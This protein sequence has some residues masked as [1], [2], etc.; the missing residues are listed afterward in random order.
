MAD[1]GLAA[2]AIVL[3]VGAVLLFFGWLAWYGNRV[4]FHPASRRTRRRLALVQVVLGIFALGFFVGAA[5]TGGGF[6]WVYLLIASGQ[7]I[8][9]LA[10]FHDLRN[11][12]TD[13]R[14]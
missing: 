8:G 13:T 10:R 3:V 14:S 4:A 1:P 7:L 2:L 12:T 11:A 5:V 6:H 9:G